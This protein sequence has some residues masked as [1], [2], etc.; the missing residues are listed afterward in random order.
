MS[1]T[2][3]EERAYWA[4]LPPKPVFGIKMMWNGEYWLSWYRKSGGRTGGHVLGK[5]EDDEF[6]WLSYEPLTKSS[7]LWPPIGDVEWNGEYWL[8]GGTLNFNSTYPVYDGSPILVKYDGQSFEDLTSNES[9]KARPPEKKPL[10]GPTA[11]LLAVL[12]VTILVLAVLGSKRL[13]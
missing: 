5:I 12:L 9:A 3:I 4:V 1:K 2:I 7:H 6:E 10:C 13:R 8:I 11:I